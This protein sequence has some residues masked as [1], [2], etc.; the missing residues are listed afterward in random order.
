MQQNAVIYNCGAFGALCCWFAGRTHLRLVVPGDRCFELQTFRAGSGY[1]MAAWL[2]DR[3]KV[4]SGY[5]SRV[6]LGI[7][8]GV[9]GFCP[10]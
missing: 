3:T 9:S 10:A 4:D 6:L 5:N 2:W 1:G 7:Q 8:S